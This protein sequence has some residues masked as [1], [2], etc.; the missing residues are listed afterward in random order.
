MIVLMDLFDGAIGSTIILAVDSS[1]GVDDNMVVMEMQSLLCC[2]QGPVADAPVVW[3]IGEL[4]CFEVVGH[5]LD[6]LPLI[7]VA[8]SATVLAQL[9]EHIMVF[10]ECWELVY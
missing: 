1:F 3:L 4:S 7:Q 2:R 6:G 5:E 9:F 8:H 10:G